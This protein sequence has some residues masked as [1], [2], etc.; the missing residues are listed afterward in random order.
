MNLKEAFQMQKILSRLLEEAASYLDDTDNVMRVT[1]KHLRSKVVPEQADEDVDCSEKFYMAYDP[2]TVLRAWHALMEEKERLGR[3][4]TQAKA[5]MTLNFDT[6]AE[7]NKARRRFLKTLA[8]LSEQRSTSRMKRGAGKG[9]V[10]NKDGNQTPYCYDIEVVK[11][12]DYDRNAVR[13]MQEALSKTAADTSRAL[14]EALLNVQV[15]YTLQLPITMPT[16]GE[17]SAE[18]RL[19]ERIFGCDGTSLTE[20]IEALE[21]K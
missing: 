18:R 10:F 1:E 16:L 21:G 11:T 4:I 13:R 17:D 12:I 8:R 5:T 7:E 2:M 6:A 14:D 3:A 15:D 9:Y 20:I 19:I